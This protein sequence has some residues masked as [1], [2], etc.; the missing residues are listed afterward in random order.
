MNVI[1]DPQRVGY[2][3]MTSED[4]FW[5]KVAKGD[6]CWEWMG[7][8]LEKGYGVFNIHPKMLKAHRLAF[9]W[10]KGAIP[11]GIHIDHICHNP[12]CVK[13]EHLRLATNKQNQENQK[14]PQARNRSG[15]RGVF[16]DKDRRKWGTLVT[17]RGRRIGA[18]HYADVEEANT[19]VV[20]KRNQLYTHNNPDRQKRKSPITT[21][22]Q[23]SDPTPK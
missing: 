9:M 20:A 2:K 21:T 15:Y 19:A 13:P 23:V 11:D 17:H 3:G 18:G 16:W 5:A 12:S 4:R 8:R 22:I 6:G 1:P 7:T 14:G 10:A